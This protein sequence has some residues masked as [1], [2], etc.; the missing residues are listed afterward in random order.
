M[1]T[2]T[3]RLVTF[4]ELE[5][6]PDTDARCELRH[7]E[8]VKVPPPKQGHHRI[9]HRLRRLLEALARDSGE[10]S[11][12]FGFRVLPEYEYRIADVVFVSR[13]RWDAVPDDSYFEGAP[14][15]V[16]QIL[17]PSNTAAGILDKEQLCLGN[18][19]VEFWVIDPKHKQA[20]VSTRDGRVATY[21]SGQ[22]IPLFF[23]GSIAVTD[24]FP[25]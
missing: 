18:G 12:E 6:M 14:D 13:D 10:V 19:S 25:G 15:L 23:G 3:N 8:L 20:R 7:G 17:S 9:Q 21:K 5:Q 2:T 4:A 1:A 22:K 16:I 11:T 24:I